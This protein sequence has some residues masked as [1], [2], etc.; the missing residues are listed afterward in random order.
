MI[1]V[2]ANYGGQPFKLRFCKLI[3]NT[4]IC[5]TIYSFM[6]PFAWTMVICN[7][8][9]MQL[10]IHFTIQQI[11][12]W[13][14]CAPVDMPNTLI[15]GNTIWRLYMKLESSKASFFFI[16]DT[17]VGIICVY[18]Q[19]L[20]VNTSWSL[21]ISLYMYIHTIVTGS[22]VLKCRIIQYEEVM[23]ILV[24]ATILPKPH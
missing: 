2:L 15:M 7:Y 13:Y 23:Y 4:N 19:N 11:L 1:A 16:H 17:L 8:L 3:G 21:G 22:K 24:S 6:V 18:Q 10:Y 20:E 14:V 12:A 9:S 5:M